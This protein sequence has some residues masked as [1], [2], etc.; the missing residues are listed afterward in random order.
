M[1]NFEEIRKKLETEKK[2]GA[3]IFSPSEIMSMEDSYFMP[4]I[5]TVLL[6]EDDVYS[7][8]KKYR[9]HYSGLLKIALGASIKWSVTDTRRTDDRKDKLYCSFMAVGGV[10]DASGTVQWH[11]AEKDIDLEVIQMELEDQYSA[12]WEK[13]KDCKGNDA[14]KKHGHTTKEAFMDALSRRDMIQ[15]RKNKLTKAESGAKARV[16]RSIIGLQGTYSNKNQLIGMPFILVH[17]VQNQNH[18]E[19][20][21]F[22]LQA[23]PAA[24][25]MIYG[26]T[27]QAKQ[28]SFFDQDA[29]VGD[30]IEVEATEVE[31]ES[32]HG[33]AEATKEDE[34]AGGF[35]PKNTDPSSGN[36]DFTNSDVDDQIKIL[37]QLC[38]D[39]GH[40]FDHHEKEN[41]KF[42]GVKGMDQAWRDEFFAYLLEE[43]EKK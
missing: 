36:I 7:A 4:V 10:V 9:I 30:V 35:K 29:D 31:E 5:E 42:G 19:V 41:K 15:H 39:V 28:I 8:Q 12:G 6:T 16:I 38:K 25:N 3:F 27:G 40:N 43:K 20:K 37:E 1:N 2:N 18:P 21:K 34:K 33:Q 23:L 14:W 13:V 32:S 11:K 24:Q 17:F 22:L 26:S